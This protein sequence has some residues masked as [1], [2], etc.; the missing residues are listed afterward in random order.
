MMRK[1]LFCYSDTV[2]KGITDVTIDHDVHERVESA[3]QDPW[4]A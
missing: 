4:K 3:I 1:R 2:V